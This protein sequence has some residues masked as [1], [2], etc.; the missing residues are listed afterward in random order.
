MLIPG[1][2]GEIRLVVLVMVVAG[3]LVAI[4][5]WI[6][7]RHPRSC[8]VLL[9][10]ASLV[11]FAGT[12]RGVYAV[13]CDMQVRR[14]SQQFR[15][16]KQNINAGKGL[17]EFMSPQERASFAGE[18]EKV[19]RSAEQAAVQYIVAEII[20]SVVFA[21]SGAWIVIAAFRRTRRSQLLN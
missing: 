16:L 21:V 2:Y 18:M 5:E 19:G 10:I 12:S 20:E 13:H 17:A 14:T 7:K 15:D 11:L 1:V 9:M 3:L 8:K 4:G 6:R